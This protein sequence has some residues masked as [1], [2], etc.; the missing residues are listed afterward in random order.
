MNYPV[1]IFL[2]SLDPDLSSLEHSRPT[3]T[4]HHWKQNELEELRKG[5]VSKFNNAF[6]GFFD[7]EYRQVRWIPTLN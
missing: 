5:R 6:V 2:S 3:G 4:Q 7:V 1:G